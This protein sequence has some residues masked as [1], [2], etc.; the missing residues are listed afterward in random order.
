[1]L[2]ATGEGGSA[3]GYHPKER[4]A[5]N[6]RFLGDCAQRCLRVCLGEMLVGQEKGVGSPQR[7]GPL[8]LATPTLRWELSSA[9][10]CPSLLPP[11]GT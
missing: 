6:R 5:I 8:Y 9:V 2:R 10:F 7:E 4:L 11:I 1:M 3:G